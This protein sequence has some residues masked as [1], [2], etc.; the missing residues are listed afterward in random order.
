[1]K[2][3]SIFT[4]MEFI[5]RSKLMAGIFTGVQTAILALILFKPKEFSVISVICFTMFLPFGVILLIKPHLIILWIIYFF[6]AGFL[7]T[8]Y[9]ASTLGILFVLLGILTAVKTDFF[10]RRKKRKALL[11]ISSLILISLCF[12]F[13]S[14]IISYNGIIRQILAILL[15]SSIFV[16]L[17]DDLR[18]Y[19]MEKPKLY[20]DEFNLT[21]RQK[22]CILEIAEGKTMSDAS[23]NINFSDSVVKKEAVEIYKIFGVKNKKEFMDFLNKFEIIP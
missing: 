21:E 2:L 23:K 7:I 11:I 19:Y 22:Q 12:Y 16:F 14:K 18:K 13:S 8:F 4:K 9:Y 5:K 20:L 1:M 6:A 17:H 3:K 15:A 10:R